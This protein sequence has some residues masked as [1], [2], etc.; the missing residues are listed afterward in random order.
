MAQLTATTVGKTVRFDGTDIEIRAHLSDDT[1]TI[2]V[3]KS[4]ACVHRL[5][6]DDAVQ[7]MEHGWIADLFAR[8]DRIA[9]SDI[10]IEAEDY[11]SKLNI[12]QG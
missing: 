3:V 5:T 6:I 10:A 1:V 12:N 8:E 4:G 11:I 9:L 2:D 7:H